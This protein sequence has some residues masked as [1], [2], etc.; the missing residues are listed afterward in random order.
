MMKLLSTLAFWTLS[1][2]VVSSGWAQAPTGSLV[3]GQVSAAQLAAFKARPVA[4]LPVSRKPA[5][6]PWVPQASL[7]TA[8]GQHSAA[9]VGGKIYVWNGYRGTNGD[10]NQEFNS[11]EIYDPATNT[12][13]AGAA[14][15]FVGRGMAST[16]GN[17]GLVYSFSGV[18][19]DFVANSYRYNPATNVWAAIANIPAAEWL[20]AA[21]TGADGRIYVFGGYN[22]N[23]ILNDNKTQI[24]NPVTNTWSTGAVMPVG[25]HGHVAV[26]DAAGIMHIIGGNG[27]NEN[28]VTAIASHLAYNPTTDTWTTLAPL[29]SVVNQAGGTLG[30][31]G[32][33]YVVGG[34]DNYINNNPNF[35]SSV[36]VYNPVANTWSG[37]DDLPIQL[38]ETKALTLGSFI[39]TVGGANGAMQAVTYRLAVA[40]VLATATVTTAT[41]SNLLET[42]ATLGGN[43]TADGGASVTERG[44]V[45]SATNATPTTADTKAANGSGTG[46]FSATIAGL[47]AGTSYTVRAYAINSEGTSYGSAESFVTAAAPADLTVNTGTAAAPTSIPA[48]TYNSITVTSAGFGQLAGAVVVNTSLTVSGG[49]NT[50]CQALTGAGSF[51]LA[52]GG[53]LGI[54]NAAGIA[55]SGATGAVQTTGPRSFSPDASYVYNGTALQSTGSGLPAQVRNL[56]TTNANVLTLTA[57]TS[58]SQALTLGN[59]N[60]SLNSQAL[61]LL[62]SASSMALVVNAGTG[63]VQGTATVQRAIDGSLNPS[64]GYRHYSAPVSNTTVADLATGSFTPTL[65]QA[66]NGSATPGATTPFPTVFGY[67]QTRLDQTS[68][69]LPAFDKGFFTPQASDPL[70]VGRGYAVNI[71]AGELVDFR[72]TLA[73]GELSVALARNAGPTAAAAGWALVGN[74]YPAPLDWRAVTPADRSGLD[75]PMYVYESTSQYGGSYRTY[76]NGFGNPLIGTAQGFFVRVSAG[77][78]EGLLTFRNGQRVTDY[79]QQVA[80]RRPTADVRPQLQLALT[81]KGLRDVLVVY[82]QAGATAG[83]DA[84]FDA[85]KLA[86]S[87]GLNLA[88]LVAAGQQLAIDGRSELAGAVPLFVGV[89]T[90]GAYTLTAA[91][92]ANLPAGTRVELVDNLSGTR[93]LLAAGT[94]YAFTTA[95][96]TAPG[97]FV[98]NLS[99]AAP[100]ATAAQALAARVLAYPNPAQGRLT[101]V[102]PA[103]GKAS[104]VLYNALGQVVKTVALPTAETVVDLSGLARGV[105]TLRLTLDGQPVSKRVVL[106]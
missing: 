74:P 8:R 14:Y 42:S 92:V 2:A 37:G 101:V 91:T 44:V 60:L 90:A 49:L 79:D 69:N 81:G 61:T 11:L 3:P 24:Y 103:G 40:P 85:A 68:N 15:P 50:N 29:P 22:P 39:Y 88:S 41:P 45:Y 36:Y 19:G 48:G 100:L 77:Q 83:L 99:A 71:G 35:F 80:V 105:Y 25:R 34:K 31:D 76:A 52:A 65:T 104:A 57:P 18:S 6:S 96:T 106:D 63:V 51:T 21:V 56:T 33:I 7:A 72:G 13:S 70:N 43:V 86:N 30:A 93:T 12:W 95:T 82:A 55:A 4:A 53:T 98:L 58:V 94:S 1:T 10:V 5:A 17:D 54:C 28:G 47:T 23:G 97:R 16:V 38:S 78:T 102:R 87:S 64:R 9:I 46:S 75:A 73:T 89:P 27:P 66:Y 67:D 20:A 59:G 62:S 84:E 26:Q 32:N